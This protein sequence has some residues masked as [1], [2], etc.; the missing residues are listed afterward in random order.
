ME[1]HSIKTRP[2]VVQSFKLCNDVDLT[3]ETLLFYNLMKLLSLGS[4]F[5]L[6]CIVSTTPV[7]QEAPPAEGN[8][9]PLGQAMAK[10][11][12]E[13]SSN[14]TSVPIEDVVP[15]TKMNVEKENPIAGAKPD[16]GNMTMHQ[17]LMLLLEVIT[18]LAAQ[19][20]SLAAA[21]SAPPA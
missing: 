17:R 8:L 3:F 19:E 9:V 15:I 12:T 6:Y 16:Y 14:G 2:D 20:Q 5:A 11:I 4:L 7:P 13:A 18:Q 21:T 10:S 1:F